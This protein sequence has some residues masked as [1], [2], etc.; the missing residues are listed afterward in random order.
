MVA[1]LPED[2]A[3]DAVAGVIILGSAVMAGGELINDWWMHTKNEKFPPKNDPPI[4]NDPDPAT[5]PARG[6]DP[7][8]V[9]KHIPP[10]WGPGE[11]TQKGGG[12]RWKAPGRPD[13]TVRKMPGNPNDPTPVKQ[14]P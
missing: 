13:T 10:E 7:S 9:D 8:E 12:W 6:I 3:G 5:N 2:P 1:A 14:G 4:V 11:P